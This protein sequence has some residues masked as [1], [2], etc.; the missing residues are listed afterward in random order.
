[1]HSG[2]NLKYPA[3]SPVPVTVRACVLG[4]QPLGLLLER[5][6]AWVGSS[7]IG[8]FGGGWFGHPRHW[9]SAQTA[10]ARPLSLGEA[11]PPEPARA[12]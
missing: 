2:Y 10:V 9:L 7:G 1:M 4:A 11:H 5:L 12:P 6:R 8:D 3:S